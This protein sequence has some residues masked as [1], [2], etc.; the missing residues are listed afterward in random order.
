MESYCI[1]HPQSP[2]AVRHPQLFLRD[3]IFVVLLDSSLGDGI[4]GL[5]PTVEA[6]LGAFDVEW[7]KALGH[8]ARVGLAKLRDRELAAAGRRQSGG[9]H[10][11]GRIRR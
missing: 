7:R 9:S 6:A 3:G 2:S 11:V 5:G 4:A 8:S 1:A 10:K